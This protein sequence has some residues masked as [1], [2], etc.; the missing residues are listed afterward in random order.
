MRRYSVLLIL[1]SLAVTAA[2][3]GERNEY[4][5]PPPPTVTVAIPARSDVT[6]FI[7]QTG[8]TRAY[9]TVDLRARVRGFLEQIN[10]VEGEDIKKGVLLFTLEKDLFEAQKNQADADVLSMQAILANAESDLARVTQLYEREAATDQQFTQAKALRD[11]SAADVAAAV[12]AAKQAEIDLSYTEVYA[13]FDGRVSEKYVDIG[14]LVGNGDATLLATILTYDPI[15]VYFS[16]NERTLLQ[17]VS[18]RQNQGGDSREDKRFPKIPVQLKLQT[19]D[20]YEFAG[21]YDYADLGVD[22]ATGTFTIRAVFRN[23]DMRLFPGLFAQVRFD[24]GTIED[25]VLIPETAVLQDQAG[26]YVLVVNDEN[27]V[28]RQSVTVGSI[29]NGFRVILTGLEGTEQVVTDGL[30]RA[31]VGGKVSPEVETLEFVP[32][33]Q[34]VVPEELDAWYDEMIQ[35]REAHREAM[36][37]TPTKEGEGTQTPDASD[38]GKSSTEATETTE[39]G[40]SADNTEKA[41]ETAATPPE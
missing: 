28:E 41:D 24:I 17:I 16:I 11:K 4:Q 8:D 33:K 9:K 38:D 40:A 2:G 18:E 22:Q 30:Q 15:Y 39:S 12:A 25:A 7:E 21:L 10:F 3:C 19:S 29:E 23:P 37:N 6:R 5:A 35:N 36:E 1:G 14:N 20:D 34:P 27:T 32:P 31:R 13:P 26:R